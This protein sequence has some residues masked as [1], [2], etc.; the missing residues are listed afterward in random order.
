MRSLVIVCLLGLTATVARAAFIEDT[1]TYGNFPQGFIWA[2]ATASYQVEGAWNVD[3][4]SK[5][6]FYISLLPHLLS[7]IQ[8]TFFLLGRT[9]SIWDTYSRVAGNIADG[10][11]GDDACKSYQ[12]YQQ[13][14]NLLKSMGVSFFLLKFL[15]WNSFNLQRTNER[16]NEL[17]VSHYRF[18]ISWSRVWPG[19]NTGAPNQLGIQYY[20]NLIAA[21]KAAN[22]KPMVTLYHWDLPQS[23]E[24]LGGWQNE[25]IATWFRDYA[26]LCFQEFGADVSSFNFNFNWRLNTKMI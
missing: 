1:L 5:F 16:T 8:F 3:G 24:D 6:S 14:V 17:Q 23:L 22:I 10:S 9:P 18:S 11:S 21:L 2:A 20:K 4:N 12:Y 15:T 26:D 19:G 25:A 13:D 7:V